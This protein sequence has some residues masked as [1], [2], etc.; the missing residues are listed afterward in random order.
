MSLK[1]TI[2]GTLFQD[3]KPKKVR[4][5]CRSYCPR[6]YYNSQSKKKKRRRNHHQILLIALGNYFGIT[7]A[8][9]VCNAN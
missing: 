5:I 8:K 6:H 4:K 9:V 1:N 2:I 7:D 3:S